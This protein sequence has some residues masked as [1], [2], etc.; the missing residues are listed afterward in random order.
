MPVAPG[1]ASP[2]LAAVEDP[3]GS[4]GKALR[5]WSGYPWYD[6][7][8]DRLARV[9]IKAPSEPFSGPNLHL[10]EILQILA[11]T[12]LALLI[13]LIVY[14][15][16]RAF[17]NH[18]G[19]EP[20]RPKGPA[21]GDAER[22][23]A[24]PLPADASLADLLAEARRQYEAGNFGQAVIYLFSYKLVQ[25]DKRQI[26]RLAKGKTDRQY[27]R[28]VGA[29]ARLRQIVERTMVAFEDV[30]FGHL[31][32]DRARFESCWSSL[33]EFEKLIEA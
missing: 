7:G 5:P 27:L 10:R 2:L 4:G 22:I 28:E 33:G 20:E 32:I 17:A 31:A 1:T 15:L 13:A 19:L 23:E 16:I 30:F 11:L 24:L 12:T 25:L 8:N 26:I 6:S 21:I 3:V 18:R 14:L 29:R 9:D